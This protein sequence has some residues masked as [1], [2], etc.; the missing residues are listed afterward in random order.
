TTSRRPVRRMSSSEMSTTTKA[1]SSSTPLML[2]TSIS[3]RF[4]TG[5]STP[6]RSPPATVR[7]RLLSRPTSAHASACTVSTTRC[8]VSSPPHAALQHQQPAKGHDGLGQRALNRADGQLDEHPQQHAE[9]NDERQREDRREAV[10]VQRAA[11]VGTGQ[12]DRAGREV[13]DLGGLVDDH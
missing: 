1:V 6:S 13:E 5:W 4:T 11:E 7:G 9:G 10:V 12:T 2:G 3:S 8:T